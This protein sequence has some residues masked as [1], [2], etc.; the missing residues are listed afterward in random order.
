V[1]NEEEP[2]PQ[3]RR[4][5]TDGEVVVTLWGLLVVTGVLWILAAIFGATGH[6]TAATWLVVAGLLTAIS[7]IIFFFWPV[8]HR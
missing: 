4:R 5:L 1:D 7:D 8:D 3:L 6:T 2:R